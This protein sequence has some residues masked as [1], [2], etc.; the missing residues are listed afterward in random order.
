MPQLLDNSTRN[1]NVRWLYTGSLVVSLIAA[2][3][4]FQNAH[5]FD[6]FS[7]LSGDIMEAESKIQSF[8]MIELV[9]AAFSITG[10]ILFLVWLY[11]SY[12]NADEF[13]SEHTTT[14][15]GWAVGGF[16]IPF[17]NLYAGYKAIK[18][19]WSLHHEKSQD[20]SKNEG[21]LPITTPSMVL[22][23]IWWCLFLITSILSNLSSRIFDES[24]YITG[25]PY[26]MHVV[27]HLLYA[28]YLIAALVMLKKLDQM[29]TDT[30]AL[31]HQQDLIDH[32][33]AE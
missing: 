7:I 1:R 22:P 4:N 19:T 27:E 6:S 5:F 30:Y 3:I 18:E 2:F 32:L 28:T 24:D 13:D 10:I 20:A 8:Q 26:T 21:A 12:Q 16:F 33:T 29:E 23:V 14:S 17:Y 25:T 11:R 31:H 15:P 9:Q